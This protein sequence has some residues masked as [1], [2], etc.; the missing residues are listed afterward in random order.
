MMSWRF[1][2]ALFRPRLVCILFTH[3]KYTAMLTAPLRT[4]RQA[5][6][7]P[8]PHHFSNIL[9][10]KLIFQFLL[11]DIWLTE[12]RCHQQPSLGRQS[13]AGGGRKENIGQ[14]T[15]EDKE[16]E[17]RER[18][19]QETVKKRD[20]SKGVKEAKGDLSCSTLSQQH[21]VFQMSIFPRR[22]STN[23][24]RWECFLELLLS[25]MSCTA[26]N[27]TNEKNPEEIRQFV[28]VLPPME[29][30]FIYKIS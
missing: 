30:S 1:Q 10:V 24:P 19:R 28:D 12:Q 18:Q 14:N 3:W 4:T 23:E 26:L 13:G 7:P 20:W 29:G 11:R 27:Q 9:T 21:A 6:L 15:E 17:E 22:C 16:E 8:P 25:L 5:H 2:P